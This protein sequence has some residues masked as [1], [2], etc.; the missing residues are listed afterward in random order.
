[1]VLPPDEG[2]AAGKPSQGTG[3]YGTRPVLE[4]DSLC[5]QARPF[6][7]CLF[8]FNAQVQIGPF[9]ETKRMKEGKT[10]AASDH[11]RSPFECTFLQ[12]THDLGPH[13][14]MKSPGC[15]EEQDLCVAQKTF[16]TPSAGSC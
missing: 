9:F 6:E 16:E 11:R 14:G 3:L 13:G 7:C 10:A 8:L 12:A 4:H 15:V 2:A 5:L 1:M